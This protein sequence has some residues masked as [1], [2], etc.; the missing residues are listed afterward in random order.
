MPRA[1]IGL[2]IAVEALKLYQERRKPRVREL[3]EYA[4]ICR[5]Q[6]VME[7]YLRALL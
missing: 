6:R 2:D 4:Q 3:L 5:V 7:P 1:V